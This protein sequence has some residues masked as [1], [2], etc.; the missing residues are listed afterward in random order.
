[1]VQ[2]SKKEII[3]T[4]DKE[5]NYR[6]EEIIYIYDFVA[7]KPCKVKRLAL[8]QKDKFNNYIQSLFDI[9]A[10]DKQTYLNYFDRLNIKENKLYNKY[11][12]EYKE[13]QS[14]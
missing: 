7:S 8:K 4:I 14:M 2:L 10:I 3:K 5:F 1:M 6:V 12:K 11:V 13:L 9:K